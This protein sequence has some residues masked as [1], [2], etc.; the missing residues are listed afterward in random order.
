MLRRS[1]PLL[2]LTFVAVVA[3]CNNFDSPSS[4]GTP[5]AVVLMNARTQAAGYTTYPKVN[6]YTVGSAVFTFSNV[7]SD[8]CIVAPF[9]STATVTTFPKRLGAGALMTMAISADTDSLYKA[10]TSDMTYTL[11]TLSGVAFNPGDSVLFNVAGD[12]AGF[13]AL[14]G[15]ARTA[16]P[17]T[18]TDPTPI[19]AGQAM[20]VSW[21]AASDLN[22]GMYVSLIYDSQG[23]GTLNTQIFCD[24]ADDGQGTVQG[25]LI[26]GLMN[27]SIP[28]VTHAQRVRSALLLTN[29]SSSRG[30]MNVIS[31]FEVPTPVSP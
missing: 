13:P 1:V 22:A 11:P 15:S 6:F 4:N 26:A 8:S 18:I 24:F 30:Y 29:A 7:N 17:F 3:A 5:V 2:V 23:T 20:P 25:N 21:T 19:A 31:T 12:V 9:D 16:E 27:S 28:F 10:T 14:T